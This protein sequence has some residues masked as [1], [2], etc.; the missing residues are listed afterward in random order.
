MFCGCD[1]EIE[2]VA[3]NTQK[4]TQEQQLKCGKHFKYNFLNAIVFLMHLIL[5]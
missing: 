1:A 3:T 2:I 5:L 4:K